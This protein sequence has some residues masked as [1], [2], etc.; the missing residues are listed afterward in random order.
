MYHILSM[1]SNKLV[2]LPQGTENIKR[3]REMVL[4]A[5]IVAG[6]SF[7]AILAGGKVDHDTIK[8]AATAFGL[9]FFTQFGIERGIKRQ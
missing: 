6:I 4:D 5:L 1:V 8:I 7:F 2:N 9:A 3:K